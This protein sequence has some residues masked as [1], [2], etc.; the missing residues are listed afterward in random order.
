MGGVGREEGWGGCRLHQRRSEIRSG[1][2]FS[3][4]EKVKIASG[5]ISCK[6]LCRLC[7]MY[8]LR[9]HKTNGPL[10]F[11]NNVFKA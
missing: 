8:I 6:L 10:L 11:V 9:M 4:E 7:S 3:S 2:V 1:S 5:M